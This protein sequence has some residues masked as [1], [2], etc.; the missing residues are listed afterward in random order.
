MIKK[1]ILFFYLLGFLFSLILFIFLFQINL[2]VKT[3]FYKGIFITIIIL[4]LQFIFLSK[5]SNLK[6]F[7]LNKLHIYIV[8]LISFCFTLTLHTLVL[9][10][11]DRAISVY[12]IGFMKKNEK[13]LSKEEIK[14]TFYKNYFEKDDAIG[15]R[16]EEQL[17]TGNIEEKNEIFFL[18]SRGESTHKI[19]FLLSELFNINNKYIDPEFNF[20]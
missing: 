8:C 12:F 4:I 17:I 1:N 18:T 20:N 10:S 13:G 5:I 16:I 9:T 11:I 6:Q 19:L 15:R 3:F 2:G 14:N 7:L